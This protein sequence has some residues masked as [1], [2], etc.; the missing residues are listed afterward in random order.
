MNDSELP[1]FINFDSN[2][3]TYSV[4]SNLYSDTGNYNIKLKAIASIDSSKID[5]SLYW[6][7]EVKYDPKLCST[8]PVIDN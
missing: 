7:L 2:T 6:S 3:R 5:D 4:N 1:D 8:I